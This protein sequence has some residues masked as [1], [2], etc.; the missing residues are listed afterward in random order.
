MLEN[1]II[2]KKPTQLEELRRRHTTDT[3]IKFYLE[4]RGESFAFYQRAH[5]AYH[6]GL[7]KTVAAIPRSARFQILEREY[8]PNFQFGNKDAVVSV[9]DDGLFVNLAKYVGTQPVIVVNPDPK[10]TSAVLA[11]CTTEEFPKLLAK[12][13][14]EK[15]DLELLTM[16]EA[17]LED[18]QIVYGL[19][20]IF[21]GMRT[22]ISARYEIEYN[23]G[24][25]RQSS[26]GIIICT[27]TG[28]TAWM[29]S[30]A[31]E[32]RSYGGTFAEVPYKRDAAHLVFA[33]R[34]PYPS[35]H[36]QTNIVHGKIG[37]Q[38]LRITSQMP[39]NGVIYS[40]GVEDDYLEFNAGKTATIRPS[41]KKV[42][43]VIG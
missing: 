20:D 33:V 18:G 41:E 42:H 3:Q 1:I 4:S 40:D 13:L 17:K 7:Q 29:S 38:P 9:G 28:S 10:H 31:A 21:V 12:T 34:E 16:A 15:S 26:S 27:G 36:T 23:R 30:K 8:L 6:D 2:V 11:S 32:V 25:E 19:N 5:D 43:R 22:H 14:Q 24:K 39:A 35:N 37:A